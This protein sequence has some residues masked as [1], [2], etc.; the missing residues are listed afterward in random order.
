MFPLSVKTAYYSYLFSLC[1]FVGVKV[2]GEDRVKYDFFPCLDE[3][4]GGSAGKSLLNFV[5][6]FE[7]NFSTQKISFVNE[8]SPNPFQKGTNGI[9]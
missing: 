7:R 3:I 9:F 5:M 6:L 8:H 2:A 1:Y 4:V